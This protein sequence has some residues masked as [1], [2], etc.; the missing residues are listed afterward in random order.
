ML[1]EVLSVLMYFFVNYM[2]YTIPIVD[3]WCK[4]WSR[5]TV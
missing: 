4:R 1:N 3:C 2:L 5:R